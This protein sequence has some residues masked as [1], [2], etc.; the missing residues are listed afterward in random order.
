MKE[1]DVRGKREPRTTLRSHFTAFAMVRVVLRNM[2]Q[3]GG[4]QHAVSSCVRL[5][6]STIPNFILSL[7]HITY[8]PSQAYRPSHTDRGC[9]SP[10]HGPQSSMPV[11]QC[12]AN[13]SVESDNLS[14]ALTQFKDK[15]SRGPHCKP[16]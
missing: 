7:L 3:N 11:P 14:K 2:M 10:P 8:C 16:V 6:L 4:G 1:Q 13:K 15:G 5:E 9:S 12:Q